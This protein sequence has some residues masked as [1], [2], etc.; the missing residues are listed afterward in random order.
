MNRVFEYAAMRALVD[1]IHRVYSSTGDFG[2]FCDDVMEFFGLEAMELESGAI[3]VYPHKSTRKHPACVIIT[4]NLAMS[5]W[6]SMLH[7]EGDFVYIFE[8]GKYD[9]AR[10][11]E[12]AS[13]RRQTK[14]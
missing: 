11:C 6:R 3:A 9:L 1:G 4:A 2:Y 5:G 12:I 14:G 8:A 7:I 13:I 10:D